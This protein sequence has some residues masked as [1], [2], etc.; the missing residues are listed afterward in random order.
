LIL[1]AIDCYC[2]NS[3]KG[4][5]VRQIEE[6]KLHYFSVYLAPGDTTR[7][8]KDT[9]TFIVFHKLNLFYNLCFQSQSS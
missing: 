8:E 5:K 1:I 6:R 9:G 2:P 4:I 3:L 7:G